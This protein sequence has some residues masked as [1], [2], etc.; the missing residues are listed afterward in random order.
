MYDEDNYRFIGKD[1]I[2][3]LTINENK[4]LLLLMK[5]KGE[6]ITIEKLCKLIYNDEG[7]YLKECIRN[8]IFRLRRKLAG[9]VDIVTVIGVGYKILSN[10][11]NYKNI[12]Y[13]PFCGKSIR[14][15]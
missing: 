3:D 12:N 1:R 13:C 9:E 15:M 4:I 11:Y 6:V 5:N 7:Y 10:I 2:I 8:K 14:E